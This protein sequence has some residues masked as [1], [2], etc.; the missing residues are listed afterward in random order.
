[1]QEVDLLFTFNFLINFKTTVY[2]IMN[3]LIGASLIVHTPYRSLAGKM[4]GCSLEH[5]CLPLF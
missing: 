2:G 4:T 1:M 3:F 5:Y